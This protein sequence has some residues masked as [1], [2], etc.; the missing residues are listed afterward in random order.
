MAFISFL[1]KFATRNITL[2]AINTMDFIFKDLDRLLR[3]THNWIVPFLQA[4]LWAM[5]LYLARY[6]NEILPFIKS[7]D[8]VIVQFLAIFIVLF[9]EVIVVLFDIYVVHKAN[10]LAPKF[11]WFIILLFMAVIGTGISVG[12]SVIESAPENVVSNAVLWVIVFSSVVKFLENLL[13]NNSKWYIVTIP[14]KFDA[15]GIYIN[16]PLMLSR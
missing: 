12:L 9:L 6:A 4:A 16:H 14:K 5:G 11:I 15:R 8:I 10:Y 1:C 2:F 13:T 3:L 7:E